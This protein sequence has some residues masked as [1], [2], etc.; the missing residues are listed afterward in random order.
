LKIS[1]EEK[2]KLLNDISD[3]VHGTSAQLALN[4]SFEKSDKIALSVL[5]RVLFFLATR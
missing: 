2:R 3:A 1:D 5:T 4:V